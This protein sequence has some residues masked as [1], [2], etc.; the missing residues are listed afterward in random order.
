MSDAAVVANA[1]DHYVLS[2]MTTLLA[3][4]QT[5]CPKYNSHGELTLTPTCTAPQGGVHSKVLLISEDLVELR[6][7]QT[8][9]VGIC[10]E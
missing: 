6:H 3:T 2:I 8:V 7:A 5:I 4:K 10:W 1:A 9:K